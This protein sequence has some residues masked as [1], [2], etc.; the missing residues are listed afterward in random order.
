MAD[1]DSLYGR[2]GGYDAIVAVV[3][4]LLPRL[5]SDDQLSRFWAHRG[6]D[7][8][9]REKQLL[10]DFIGACAG[11]PLLYTGREMK[12]S[13]VGMGSSESD[14][15]AFI[16]HLNATLDQFAV[17]AQERGDVLAFVD[18]TKADIVDA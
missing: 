12:K 9:D 4:N 18:S 10:V 14:W 16:G 11:G 8:L 13:H 2:L 7:G 6:T 1:G 17:P 5:M 3:D 15:T